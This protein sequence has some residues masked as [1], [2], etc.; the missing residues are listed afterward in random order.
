MVNAKLSSDILDIVLMIVVLCNLYRLVDGGTSFQFRISYSWVSI[1]RLQVP[2]KTVLGCTQLK[3]NL[4]GNYLMA[5]CLHLKTTSIFLRGSGQLHPP[6][7][8][9][10][11]FTMC[12]A[13]RIPS[14]YLEDIVPV[15]D[16]VTCH[17]SLMCTGMLSKLLY[18]MR[19]RRPQMC[20]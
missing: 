10:N 17:K 7:S 2:N 15:L 4:K 18:H 8:T 19:V 20:S 11:C 12:P 13:L 14:W 5:A 3:D 1:Y 9:E 6:N 16:L